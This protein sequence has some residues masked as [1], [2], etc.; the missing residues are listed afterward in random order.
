MTDTSEKTK[1]RLLDMY[2]AVPGPRRLE[3]GCGMFDD[4]KA[5]AAAG[6]LSECPGLSGRELRKRLF[7]RLFGDDFTTEKARKILQHLENA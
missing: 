6:I 5:L 1:A 7:Q 3:M 2:K 4:A